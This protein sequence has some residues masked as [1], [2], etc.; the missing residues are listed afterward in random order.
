MSGESS[1]S[2]GGIGF[3]GLLLLVFVCAK[4]F[5]VDPVAHWSWWWVLA[6]FWIPLGILVTVLA[7]VGVI[8]VVKK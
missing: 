1:A 7:A 2:S 4:I 6:P 3:F 8:A 5:G